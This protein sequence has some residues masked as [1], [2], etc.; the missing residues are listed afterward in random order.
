MKESTPISEQVINEEFVDI[1]PELP[2]VKAPPSTM[3]MEEI[4]DC[5][6]SAVK[7][8]NAVPRVLST[9][10][11]SIPDD[12]KVQIFDEIVK[13]IPSQYRRR[14]VRACAGDDF[15]R[16]LQMIAK[17]IPLLKMIS[18]FADVN[19]SDPFLF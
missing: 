12:V 14:I 19:G 2:I 15:Q 6:S 4:A 1:K 18:T 13:V 16:T 3:D 7:V 17:N 5:V 9:P 8:M 10:S 11:H